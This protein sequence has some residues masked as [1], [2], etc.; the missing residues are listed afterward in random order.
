MKIKICGITN[1]DDAL[2]CID[3]GADALGFIM[4]EKSPRYIGI[5]ETESI[6]SRLPFFVQKI[7]VF[8]NIEAEKVNDIAK[9]SGLN[10]VQLHGNESPDYI[11]QINLPVIKSFRITNNFDF[12]KLKSYTNCTFLLD[13]FSEPAIGGTGVNFNWNL[14]PDN[15]K[16]EIILAGGISSLN[17]ETII[18]TIKPQAVDLSSSLESSPGKKDHKK[19][20][21]F[22][23]IYKS[24]KVV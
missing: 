16:P 23:K 13:N 10:G 6:I 22:F 4:T 24:L 11:K 3:E 5:T 18:K 20:K 7:G 2:F 9:K 12:A 19:V 14:I 17:I 8:V 21:E 15:L 1:P